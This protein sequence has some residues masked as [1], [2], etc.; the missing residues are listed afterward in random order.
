MAACFVHELKAPDVASPPNYD[1]GVGIERG[2]SSAGSTPWGLAT[3]AVSSLLQHAVGSRKDQVRITIDN[4]FSSKIYTSGSDITG[5]VVVKPVRDMQFDTVDI[6]LV[7]TAET[8][9]DSVETVHVT[10][11]RFLRLQ[12]PISTSEYPASQVFEAGKIYTFPFHFI[13]PAHLTSKACTHRTQ[14]EH[15]WE[16]HTNLPASM[17]TWDKD[18]M[19]PNMA[20]I[21]YAVRAHVV[22]KSRHGFASVADDLHSINVMPTSF[23]EPP[24]SITEKDQLYTLEKAKNVRKNLFSPKQGRI[25]AVAAQPPAIRLSNQGH[26][27]SSSTIPITLTF[28]PTSAAIMPPQFNTIGVKARAI[29]YF[30]DSPMQALPNMGPQLDGYS[31]PESVSIQSPGKPTIE[32]TQHVDLSQSEQKGS[33]PI[34][35]TATFEVPLRLPTADKTFVPTFHSCVVARVY[36]VRV[37]LEGDVKIDLTVPVQVVMEPELPDVF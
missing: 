20:R 9:R 2:S 27:A 10:T 7:G 4:H 31:Y 21:V 17:G 1:S 25:T 34:F 26:E 37:V 16:R 19:A 18:D 36:T 3:N 5:Q 35:H 33:S 22:S 30:R 12:M 29:T 28:E 8:R 14:S 24:L 11:H 32:W 15:V 23:E 6:L 13:L